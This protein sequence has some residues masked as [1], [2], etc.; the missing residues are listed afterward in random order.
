M[1]FPSLFPMFLKLCMACGRQPFW[2][3]AK[4]LMRGFS[5]ALTVVS[6]IAGLLVPAFLMTLA[7]FR[8]T[9]RDG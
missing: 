2:A 8:V 5:W 6:D 3:V 4:V 7:F 9:V 1:Y